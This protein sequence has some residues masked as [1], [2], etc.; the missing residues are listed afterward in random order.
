MPGQLLLQHMRDQDKTLTRCRLQY[1]ILKVARA[2]FLW[3]G[4]SR[5]TD[6][7]ETAILNGILGEAGSSAPEEVL[8]PPAGVVLSSNAAL[9][10]SAPS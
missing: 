3:T 5:F 7:Y 8:W 10:A 6:F 1:N 9:P 2:L 4:S